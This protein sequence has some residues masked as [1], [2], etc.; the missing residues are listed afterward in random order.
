MSGGTQSGGDVVLLDGVRT[1]V[2][3]MGRRWADVDAVDLGAR[4]VRGLLERTD[5]AAVDY[6]ALGNVVQAG[7]GQNPARAAAVRGGV[8]RTTPGITLNDVCLASMTSLELAAMRTTSGNDD[9]VLVGG[10]ESMSRSPREPDD[11]LVRDG[12]WCSLGDIG[13]GPLSDAENERLAISRA[14]QDA[15]AAAS[16]QHAIAA[17]R[18]GR[19][20]E[21]MLAGEEIDEG[22]RPETTL[23]TLSGLAPAFTPGGTITAANASQMSDAAAVGIVTTRRRARELGMGPLVEIVDSATVA[24]P[25]S[26]LH[27]QPAVAA[28]QLLRRNGLPAGAVDL[29]EI[30]EAFAGVVLASQRALGIALERVNVNG[31]AIA[32]GHPLGASGMRLTLTLAHEMRRR[33]VQWGIATICGG[34]GQARA[35]LLRGI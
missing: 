5:G 14:D 26:S 27:E 23:E 33:A 2:G 12:L 21:E 16:H 1:S 9:A 35:I 18:A 25:T 19:L 31:G 22:I 28:E 34:G 32:L 4:A 30:N 24:G 3:R 7:N 13:M 10:F 29:W 11:L 20:A 8:E 6:V 17:S 15:V